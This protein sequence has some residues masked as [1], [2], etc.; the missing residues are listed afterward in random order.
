MAE[1][2]LGNIKGPRGEKG[3]QGEAGTGLT[4]LDYYTT[5]EELSSAITNPS[6]GDAYGVGSAAPYNIYIY[7]QSNGWVNNGVLQGA[8]GEQGIQGE[9]GPQGIQGEKG[10]KGT[11]GI[12][13]VDGVDGTNATITDV[14]ATVDETTGT[15]TVTV[16][17][18]GTESKRSFAFSFSGL[19]GERGPQGIQGEKG[20]S[21]NGA[22]VDINEQTP[23]YAE[24]STLA[25]LT[26]GEKISIAFG[27]I[28]KAITDF[29]SHLADT[30]KHITST[31]RNT[32]NG[33]ANSVHT[34]SNYDSHL[35]D[36]LN[37]HGIT[38]SQIG[39]SRIQVGSYSGIGK[40]GSANPNILNLNFE[41]KMVLVYTNNHNDGVGPVADKEYT[42]ISYSYTKQVFLHGAT[43]FN[44]VYG[45][46]LTKDEDTG[47]LF[48]THIS[49]TTRY[50][51]AGTTLSWYH[52][53]QYDD[54]YIKENYGPDLQMNIEGTTY[55]YVAIG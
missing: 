25:T 44:V 9:R 26:S 36:K 14:T 54:E 47:N 3:P 7:S 32:W 37:P 41:P 2:L 45:K 20:E 40:S 23:T 46:G 50:S 5:V 31:E 29:I 30:T 22:S 4:V 16:T 15:P 6:A 19:K 28:K 55:Y 13:G 33:K 1:F 8:K 39:A 53:C 34:H 21:G 17:M 51:I 42:T 11:D 12:N 18:G 49:G 35:S 24:A 48:E 43:R 52:T 27:K 10:E 38:P